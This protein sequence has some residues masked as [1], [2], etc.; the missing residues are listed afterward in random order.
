MHL[1]P[2]ERDP[3]G[4]S[5][6]WHDRL[7]DVLQADAEGFLARVAN[8][9]DW[10]SGWRVDLNGLQQ[11]GA[12]IVFSVLYWPPAEFDF[13]KKY[14]SPPLP[15]Y[16]EDVKYQLKRVEDELDARKREGNEL[17][18]AKERADLDRNGIVFVHCVEGGFH[19]GP[20]DEGEIDARVAW[21]ADQGVVYIT[22]AHLFYRGVATNAPAIPMLTAREYETLFHEPGLGLTKLG[23]AA[24]RAMY[25][26][27]VLIDI[28]HMSQEAIDD[29][30]KLVET[31]D[32]EKKA[33]PCDYPLLATH[34]GMRQAGPNDQSYNLSAATAERIH[35]R[36]GL[37]GLITAQHQIGTTCTR[38]G[39]RKAVRRHMDA[40]RDACGNHTATALGTDIDG[41]IKPTLKGFQTAADYAVLAEW[42]EEDQG[43]DAKAIL[44]DNARGV[45]ERLF[46]AREAAAQ[47]RS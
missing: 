17:V 12:R 41:F 39:A 8:N 47:P 26:H 42:V 32:N 4:P 22:L 13:A 21:L 23:E 46:A 11:G 43:A 36:G 19:L 7:R 33:K 28:S 37:I 27:R 30:F 45:L 6:N 44:H 2:G 35:A 18:I 20:G 15:V 16:Y 3:G 24:V 14:G 31:L 5:V 40:I 34:V 25:K 1:L 38:K 10:I 9:R 29:T